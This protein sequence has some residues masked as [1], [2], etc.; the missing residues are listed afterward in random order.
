MIRSSLAAL[1]AAVIAV[2]AGVMEST[3]AQSPASPAERPANTALAKPATYSAPRTPWGD[4]D[5]QGVWSSDEEA[6]VPLERPSGQD[7]PSVEITFEDGRIMTV[8]QWM[9]K[10]SLVLLAPAIGE[11]LEV[12]YVREERKGSKG[13]KLFRGSVTRLD[14]SVEKFDHTVS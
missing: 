5:L 2:G 6:G 14:G 9:L 13:T 11:T 8:G 10:R 1:G 12:I 7:K 3:S 4:P